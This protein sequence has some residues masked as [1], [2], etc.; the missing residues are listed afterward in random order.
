MK[1]LK[2]STKYNSYRFVGKIN[3]DE[4]MPWFDFDSGKPW[5]EGEIPWPLENKVRREILLILSNTGPKTFDE[6]YNL[7][8]FSP[9][10]LLITE[11]EHRAKIKYQWTK[12][13]V[14]NHLLNLE[15][16]NLIRKIDDKYEVTFP[17]FK[18]ENLSD[19][20]KYIEVI[21]NNWIE[22]IRSNKEE[23]NRNLSNYADTS[24]LYQVL[25]DKA[26]E[27]LYTLLKSE[28]LLPNQANIKVLWAEQLRD[29]K[30]EKWVEK[31]F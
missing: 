20:R 19:M 3:I 4:I 7:I 6:I 2:E 5:D 8:N 26:I 12:I 24:D 9:K 22:V 11:Q 13:T 10:P 25:I 1:N 31:N 15:W 27:R 21:A 14:E 18:M 23:I 16:Y 17:V 29:I 30:F 28:N